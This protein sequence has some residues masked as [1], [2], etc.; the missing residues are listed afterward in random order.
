MVSNSEKTTVQRDTKTKVRD[1]YETPT[2]TEFG[3]VAALTQAGTMMSPEMRNNMG[4][5]TGVMML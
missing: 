5:L 2:I 1:A 4:M 3:H